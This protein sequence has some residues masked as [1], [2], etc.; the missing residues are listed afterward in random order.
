M[1][2]VDLEDDVYEYVLKNAAE[3]GEDASSILRPR[4]LLALAPA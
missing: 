2:S 1:R 4:T 3:I